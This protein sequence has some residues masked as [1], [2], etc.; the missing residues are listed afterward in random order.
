MGTDTVVQDGRFTSFLR[1]QW[2]WGAVAL[3]LFVLYALFGFFVVP[4][5]VRNQIVEQARTTLH[6]QATV[7]EVRFNPFT[8]ALT[9]GRL[10]LADRDGADLAAFDL[11]RADLEVAGI[12]RRALRFK[13]IRVERPSIA[14]RILADGRPS[15]SDLME[16]NSAAAST[17]YQPPR[18]IVDRLTVN[19]G[20]IQFTDASH[21]PLH[22]SRFE[23]LS[24][25]VKDLIT[26]PQE[27]GSHTITI[28]IG[29]GAELHW[30]GQQTVEPLSFTGKLDIKGLELRGL[31][32]YFG[33]GQM[34]DVAD[35]R[36]DLTIPYDISRGTDRQMHVTVDS[37]SATVHTLVVRAAGE[38]T[39]W[40][41]VPE[42]RVTDVKAGW[43]ASSVVVGGVRIAG[44]R[45]LVRLEQ[46][47][48][49]N[50]SKAL[51]PT[52]ESSTKP[53]WM[54][55]LA[56]FD[57]DGGSVAF[58]D[59]GQ[60]PATNL[61]LADLVVHA[62]EITGN[63]ARPIPLTARARLGERGTLEGSGTIAPSPMA[64][65]VKFAVSDID[66]V[67]LRPYIQTLQGA[68]F[69]SGKATLQGQV[70]VS[71]DNQAIKL[72]ANGSVDEV[73]L[74]DMGGERLVAWQKMAIDGLTIEDPPNRL[75]VRALT[76]DQPFAK[77]LIDK[78]GN[79][80]LTT[81]T[82]GK[83]SASPPS[84]PGEAAGPARTVE[85][86]TVELRNGTAE[87]TDQSM[88]L[89]F[90]AMIHS[91]GGTIRDLSSF[92]SAPATL[93]IEGRVDETGYVK[94]GGTLRL[95]DPMAASEISV[96]FRSIEMPT[97]TPYFA[98][99]AG[100]RIRQGVLDLD[101]RYTVSDRRLLGN[102]RVLARDLNLGD[103]VDG[104][105]AAPLPIRLAV[106]LLKD[107]DGRINLDVPIEGTVDSPEFAYRKVFWAAV[108]TILGNAVKA[109]FR[110]LGR[111]FGRDEDDLELVEFD[112]GRSDLLP[113]EQA[114]LGRI[115]EQIAQR[116]DLTIS[117]EGRFDP[118]AD[119]DALKRAKLEK[120][121]ESRRDTAAAAAAAA[122]GSTLE[123]ILE[124][125]FVEQFSADALQAERQRFTQA[126]AAGAPAAGAQPA[127][128]A[129]PAAVTAPPQGASASS[130]PPDAA[131]PATPAPAAAFDAAGFYESLRAKL[132]E[133]QSVTPADLSTL[134]T[135]RSASIVAV[136]T[137]S[138]TVEAARVSTSEPTA[139]KRKKANSNRIAAEMT[140]SADGAAE[141]AETN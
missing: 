26:I 106:A 68:R 82:T 118:V 12:F 49:L 125:L 39:D 128:T 113:A 140:M 85:I 98:E 50:W 120:L 67:P 64:A 96:E 2:K 20:V 56:S 124:G 33:E 47:G 91:A 18:L 21:H 41:T 122:G 23:P 63:A 107:K 109:P 62:S 121:I 9:I 117:V 51:P 66:L 58:E 5:I 114:T 90:R 28:G 76:V 42:V 71:G 52:T 3:A 32:D 129:P 48:M 7:G 75:R 37:A 132:L 55:R 1:R 94:A 83:E 92:S 89:E 15:V 81:L 14:A 8:L 95:A 60:Q 72:A 131:T 16:S 25:D 53:A 110:A 127:A 112:P 45:A 57:I 136:L 70:A 93:A 40:L 86:N 17:P 30:T 24:L 22:Q 134:A 79:L 111:L 4:W 119:T 74:Q 80:N 135:A 87:Y 100:Y 88:L 126:P 19:G 115:A 54:F 78:N 43:P 104:S 44:P 102:H 34:L 99:F 35:G 97:L 101:V 29:E 84:P 141:K 73:E 38:S 123:T 77:I 69:G 31:W 108:R 46:D 103:K 133:A 139:V 59:L 11:L 61:D 130:Q 6:R 65:D 116:R 27:K 137:G 138:G 10:K 13:E 36:A 105:K